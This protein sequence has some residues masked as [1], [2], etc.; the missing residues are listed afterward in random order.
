MDKNIFCFMLVIYYTKIILQ[1]EAGFKLLQ[2]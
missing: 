1:T 2:K